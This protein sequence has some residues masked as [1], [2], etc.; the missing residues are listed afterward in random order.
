[1]TRILGSSGSAI[2][3][4]RRV[5][6]RSG[7]NRHSRP[8][9]PSQPRHHYSR[10]QLPAARETAHRLAEGAGHRTERASTDM[11][12]S[13]PRWVHRNLPRAAPPDS[14]RS[15]RSAR[16]P[17][18]H[19]LDKPIRS[20]LGATSL[21]PGVQFSMSK[22][23]HFRTSVDTPLEAY[24]VGEGYCPVHKIIANVLI[25]RKSSA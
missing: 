24:F 20:S 1:M 10:R 8:P 9:A 15:L 7:S 22:T 18:V 3:A 12:K 5:R 19:Y 16:V 13:L 23:V 25:S 6:R 17:P 4:S 21:K 2:V 14:W 11:T